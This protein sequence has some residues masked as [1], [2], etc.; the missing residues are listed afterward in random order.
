VNKT[1][2]GFFPSMLRKSI[3]NKVGLDDYCIAYLI[4]WF[5]P[6]E[7]MNPGV[8]HHSLQNDDPAAG[9]AAIV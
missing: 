1:I 7:T 6:P 8:V 4:L 2:E 5:K 9:A 3:S